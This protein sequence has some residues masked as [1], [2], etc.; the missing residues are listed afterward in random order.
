[1]KKFSDKP[2]KMQEK[3]DL[4]QMKRFIDL[5]RIIYLT[6]PQ[7][8][9]ACSIASL[10]CVWNTLLSTKINKILKPE[11]LG[12]VLGLDVKDPQNP[13][14]NTNLDW[15]KNW[16]EQYLKNKSE[17]PKFEWSMVSNE[18]LKDWFNELLKHFNLKGKCSTLINKQ[19][20]DAQSF[21]KIDAA[22]REGSN[23]L[24]YHGKNHY[25]LLIGVFQSANKPERCYD[26]Y[27]DDLEDWLIFGEHSV[28]ERPDKPLPTPI[29]SVR[30]NDI[31]KTIKEENPNN[32]Y[33]IMIFSNS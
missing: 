2:K 20:V 10:T 22:L 21:N 23:V 8:P 26:P 9:K 13:L 18:T 31:K 5:N 19:N 4:N 14:R 7:Y 12:K 28:K 25:N 15:V 32:H 17:P 1:M 6:R 27:P 24:I 30:F 16:E 33:C 11:D 29:K 3:L